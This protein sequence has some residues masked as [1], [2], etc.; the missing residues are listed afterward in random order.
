MI[1]S[2]INSNAPDLHSQGKTN[3][4][5]EKSFENKQLL[6]LKKGQRT[7]FLTLFPPLSLNTLPQRHSYSGIT[8]VLFTG[9]Q[10]INGIAE[11]PVTTDNSLRWTKP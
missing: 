5:V 2:V 7:T 9:H 1:P 3:S 8:E 4:A 11:D 10:N 6:V